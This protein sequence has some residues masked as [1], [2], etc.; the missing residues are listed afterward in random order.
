MSKV[1]H[2]CED[3]SGHVNQTIE[4]L[5]NVNSTFAPCVPQKPAECTLTMEVHKNF[6]DFINAMKVFAE[7]LYDASSGKKSD[8]G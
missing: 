4:V 5:E 1:H 7:K 2:L 3:K 6:A 8:Q